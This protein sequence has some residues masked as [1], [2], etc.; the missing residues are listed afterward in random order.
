MT[1]VS[2]MSVLGRLR[3]RRSAPWMLLAA[4]SV[5]F[6][7]TAASCQLTG[8]SVSAGERIER[9]IQ[10]AGLT[11]EY[12][13]HTPR[14]MNDREPHKVLFVF[15]PGG[16][17]A[18]FME[19]NAAFHTAAGAEDFVVVYPEGVSRTFNAGVC[20]GLALEQGV[21]DV[22]FF[23]AMM[24]DIASIIPIRNKAY[25]TGFSNGAMLTYRLICEAPQLVAAAVPFAGAVPMNNCVSGHKVPVMH[26]NGGSDSQ[27]LYGGE[28]NTPSRF[29]STSRFLTPPLEALGAIARRNG[30]TTT[31]EAGDSIPAIDANCERYAGCPGD[32]PVRMCVIPEL[33]HAWPGSGGSQFGGMMGGEN[34]NN[35]FRQ[36]PGRMGN[37]RREGSFNAADMSERLGPF[38]PELD[39]TGPIIQFLR[40]F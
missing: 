31:L 39:G 40:R 23:R 27:S 32:A 12:I 29:P 34:G 28:R 37:F 7:S 1:L 5:V 3:R 25:L 33:G 2:Q 8:T 4:L 36:F 24:K 20:C 16:A 26:L 35:G 13:L 38:R 21:D 9:E 30:C 11:R 22:A 19:N 14:E 10:V 17:Q 18:A 6:M 15:H